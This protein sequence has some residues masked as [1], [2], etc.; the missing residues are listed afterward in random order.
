MGMEYVHFLSFDERFCGT[1]EQGRRVHP[2]ASDVTCPMC[3]RKACVDHEDH[4]RFLGHIA[5]YCP[6]CEQPFSPDPDD[7]S[8]AA[9]RFS[10]EAD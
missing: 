1:T 2:D 9:D 3:R 6:D 7:R 4:A 8:I 5:D 10:R